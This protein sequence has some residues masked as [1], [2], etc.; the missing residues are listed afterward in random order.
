M[1][2]LIVGLEYDWDSDYSG[3]MT[4][5]RVLESSSPD[6]R[7]QFKTEDN[8]NFDLACKLPCLFMNEGKDERIARVGYINHL[9]K[10]DGGKRVTFEF[11]IDNN[12]APLT[13]LEIFESKYSLLINDFEFTRCHWAIKDVDLYK[14]LYQRSKIPRQRPKAFRLREYEY[15]NQKKISVMMPFDA[16]YDDVYEIIQEAAKELN[17]T[18]ERADNYW[19]NDAVIQDIVELIDTSRIVLCDLTK[20]APNVYYEA[21]IAHTL[22][23][24]TIFLTQNI[25]SSPFD[26]KHIRHII[27]TNNKS[28]RSKLKGDLINKLADLTDKKDS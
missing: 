9:A 28:G 11:I 1:Y 21:G 8:I 12:T 24:E 13:N 18:C 22:G 6:I 23:R 5:D 20:K 10:Q 27:Y 7:S 14:F 2:N 19:K 17:L 26:V 15:I 25:E 16:E 3:E 4:L